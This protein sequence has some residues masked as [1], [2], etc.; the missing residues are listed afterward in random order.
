MNNVPTV[1][2]QTQFSFGGVEM[3]NGDGTGILLLCSTIVGLPAVLIL[4][5][6]F[7]PC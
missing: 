5:T 7:V 2:S 4:T 1:F 6:V 3:E